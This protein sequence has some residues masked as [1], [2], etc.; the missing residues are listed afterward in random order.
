M[1]VVPR[2]AQAAV[3]ASVIVDAGAY[4]PTALRALLAALAAAPDPG[5]EILLIDDGQ[6]DVAAAADRDPRVVH[7]NLPRA[8]ALAAMACNAAMAL[9]S[10]A[11]LHYRLGWLTTAP[12]AGAAAPGLDGLSHPRA[13]LA[14]TGV[15]DPHLLLR[16]VWAEDLRHRLQRAA[17]Q[18]APAPVTADPLVQAGL[19]RDRAPA[20]AAT[21]TGATDV[22]AAAFLRDA[23]S[24]RRF[25]EDWVIPFAARYWHASPSDPSLVEHRVV[26]RPLRLLV[27]GAVQ[28]AGAEIVFGNPARRFPSLLQVDRVG[29]NHPVAEAPAHDLLINYRYAGPLDA[30]LHAAMRGQGRPVLY[31]MD[32]NLPRLSEMPFF[33]REPWTRDTEQVRAHLREADG[34]LTWSERCAADVRHRGAWV[35]ALRTQIE[36]ARLPASSSPP[37]ADG[38]LVYTTLTRSVAQRTHWW[39]AASAAWTRFFRAHRDRARLVLFGTEPASLAHYAAW[40][41]DIDYEVRPSMPYLD[42]LTAIA[43]GQFHFV[44]SQVVEDTEFARAKCPIKLLE[45]TAAGA[46]LLAPEGVVY[47]EVT[48]GREGLKVGTEPGGWTTALEHSLALS[49]GDREALWA[50]AR[51]RVLRDHTTEAQFLPLALACHGA[52]LRAALVARSG[53]AAGPPQPGLPAAA[54]SAVAAAGAPPRL[55]AVV[56]TDASGRRAVLS[57]AC[58]LRRQGWRVRTAAATVT[59]RT[60]LGSGRP[61]PHL[62]LAPSPWSDWVVAAR[63]AGLVCAALCDIGDVWPARRAPTATDQPHVLLTRGMQAAELARQAGWGFVR[64]LDVPLPGPAGLAQIRAAAARRVVCGSDAAVPAEPGSE[65]TW[66]LTGLGGAVVDAVLAAMATGMRVVS[67]GSLDASELLPNAPWRDPGPPREDSTEWPA[68]DAQAARLAAA[69]RTD[70]GRIAHDLTGALIEAVQIANRDDCRPA[71]DRGVTALSDGGQVT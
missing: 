43:G 26:A 38:R 34:V 63:R 5:W 15:A 61:R 4:A 11:V 50:A 44:L 56:P 29:P 16:A 40:F 22:L 2:R 53:H 66:C 42:Y 46:V 39:Q 58:L 27:R 18:P 55:L 59:P 23:E 57:W 35:I 52:R 30:A 19:T 24:R 33:A 64:R 67:S 51:D 10:G 3:A 41:A 8:R 71:G 70:P 36:A 13:L 20:L 60:A 31:A 37:P 14:A 9:A 68:G 25:Q 49:D 21:T 69:A 48:H 17:G 32:D 1:R 28:S 54:G 7:L 62:V 47:Q 12:A 6:V 45:A 65:G